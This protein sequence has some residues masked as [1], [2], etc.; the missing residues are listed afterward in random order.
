MCENI[1]CEN[2]N[3]LKE[4]DGGEP[5]RAASFHRLFFPQVAPSLLVT[6]RHFSMLHLSTCGGQPSMW[7]PHVKFPACCFPVP[8]LECRRICSDQVRI[9]MRLHIFVELYNACNRLDGQT[10]CPPTA[11]GSYIPYLAPDP[12]RTLTPSNQATN[13]QQYTTSLP[14]TNSL[15]PYAPTA[16]SRSSKPTSPSIPT[17]T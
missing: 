10:Q 3:K 15:S 5:D 14:P 2:I 6:T 9:L 13:E 8:H 7:D 16:P 17:E 11:P 1:V 12:I 4:P